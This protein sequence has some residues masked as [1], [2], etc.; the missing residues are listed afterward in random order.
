MSLKRLRP[1]E[2]PNEF[3]V[4]DSGREV[5]R[6]MVVGDHPI[7]YEREQILRANFLECQLDD[8]IVN[9]SVPHGAVFGYFYENYDSGG[10]QLPD[11]LLVRFV[12][13]PFD[14]VSGYLTG[15]DLKA[16]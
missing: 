6:G 2:R 1:A 15:S 4:G 16:R 14:R 5:V 3:Y 11:K 10:G 8:L 12:R 7:E 9:G 13:K